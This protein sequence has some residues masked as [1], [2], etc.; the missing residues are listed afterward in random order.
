[1]SKRRSVWNESVYQKRLAVQVG[2]EDPFAGGEEV[3]A[4]GKG[5]HASGLLDDI[6]YDSPYKEVVVG[7]DRYGLVLGVQL[8]A[9]TENDP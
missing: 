2:T 1:M 4:V 5:V 8:V 7:P 3:V 6:G 9:G